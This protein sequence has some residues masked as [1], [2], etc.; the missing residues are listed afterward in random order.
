MSAAQRPI[1]HEH[2]KKFVIVGGFPSIRQALVERGWTQ[3]EDASSIDWNLKYVIRKK[4]V[5]FPR[6]R[7]FQIVNYYPAD[8]EFTTKHALSKNLTNLCFVDDPADHEQPPDQTSRSVD[9]DCFYPR[10]YDLCS[11]SS[12]FAEDFKVGKCLA[13]LKHFVRRMDVDVVGAKGSAVAAQEGAPPPTEQLRLLRDFPGGGAE[14]LF[15]LVETASNILERRLSTVDDLITK[16][17]D[18]AHARES[19]WA[20]LQN[21][22]LGDLSNRLPVYNRVRNRHQVL[23]GGRI[24]VLTTKKKKKKKKIS[25][26]SSNDEKGGGD[27]ELCQRAVSLLDK[28]VQLLSDYR[29]VDPQYGLFGERNLWIVKPAGKS[30]GR[31]IFVSDRLEEILDCGRGQEALWVAQKYCR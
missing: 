10:C 20:L 31:G 21:V 25:K 14:V 22:D 7:D 17:S 2:S 24:V 15:Q 12:A 26:S 13:V 11:E 8:H 6:L 19:E 29:I 23:A 18:F 3:Q 27:A 28:T 16:G 4:D 1:A 9:L 5:D 30:R